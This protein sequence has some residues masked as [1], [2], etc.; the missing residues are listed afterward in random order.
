MFS[1]KY[2]DDNVE[3]DMKLKNV[4]TLDGLI[5]NFEDFVRATGFSW[6]EP[7]SIQYIKPE[8]D[9]QTF[10]TAQ[11]DKNQLGLFSHKAESLLSARGNE[12]E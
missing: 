11:D 5:E 1:F 10:Q 3:L 12:S 6:V 7:N 8:E 2:E 9:N 4:V